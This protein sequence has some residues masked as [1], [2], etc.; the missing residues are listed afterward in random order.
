MEIA[1]PTKN[2]GIGT[3]CYYLA[4]FLRKTLGHDVTVLLGSPPLKDKDSCF[5]KSYFREKIDIEFEHV[6]DYQAFSDLPGPGNFH[7]AHEW[8]LN[9]YARLK[10]CSYDI[11]HFQDNNANAFV[12][13]MAKKAGLHF[14]NTLFT[15]T[16][17]SPDQWIRRA[18]RQYS[19][20]G[21]KDMHMDF[22]ERQG[23]EMCDYI[24]APVNYMLEYDINFFSKV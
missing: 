6:N 19:H 1:G 22:M 7:Y 23:A 2:G 18:N 14:R 5:W 24:V 8:S 21:G 9:L 17:H 3:H 12:S 11:C 13:S 16:L 4:K 10:D 20:A 15:C